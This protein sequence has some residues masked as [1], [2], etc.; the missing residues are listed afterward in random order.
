MIKKN[1]FKTMTLIVLCTMVFAGCGRKKVTVDTSIQQESRAG[2]SKD[3]KKKVASNQEQVTVAVKDADGNMVEVAGIVETKDNGETVVVV[4]DSEGNRTEISAGGFTS[5]DNR[6]VTITDEKASEAISSAVAENKVPKADEIIEIPDSG[7]N[8]DDSDNDSDND[9]GNESSG[10][11]D[12]NGSSSG[13]NNGGSSN[14]SDG[15]D[16][17]GGNNSGNNNNN[18]NGSSSGNSGNTSTPD[19]PS[20]THNWKPVYKTVHHEAVTHKEDRWVVDKAA[21]DEAVTKLVYICKNC[22]LGN[23]DRCKSLGIINYEYDSKDALYSH[24]DPCL[25]DGGSCSFWS[26]ERRVDHYIHHD[27][28]GHYETVTITDKEAWDEQVIDHYECD[29]GEIK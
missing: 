13:S 7:N 5:D 28:E 27:E 25:E 18:N 20:H 2:D 3:D 26:T 4:T 8:N 6:I 1:L 21:W 29:C 22:R 10:D 12:G 23:C 16:N 14:G 17:N 9:S 24:Q 11:S 19:T 15:S